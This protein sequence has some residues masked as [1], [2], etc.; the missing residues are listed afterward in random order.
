M[1]L[2]FS[3]FFGEIVRDIQL[4]IVFIDTS[5]TG[6]SPAYGRLNSNYFQIMGAKS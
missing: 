3:I 2:G 5:R 4:L 6:C 1:I